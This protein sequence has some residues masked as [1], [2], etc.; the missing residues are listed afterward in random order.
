MERPCTESILCH[1]IAS[2]VR[3]S[4]RIDYNWA[5][6][7]SLVGVVDGELLSLEGEVPVQV[8]V[9]R[10]GV[11]LPDRGDSNVVLQEAWCE[12]NT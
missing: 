5:Y 10:F 4:R 6:G 9:R 3:L 1:L 7:P 8:I 12:R 2:K 11:D